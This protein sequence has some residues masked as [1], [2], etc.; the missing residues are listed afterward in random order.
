VRQL[1]SK[2][3]SQGISNE[4]DLAQLLATRWNI[5]GVEEWYFSVKRISKDLRVS[6]DIDLLRVY[7]NRHYPEENRAVGFE[8]KV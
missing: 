4:R 1:T 3:L 5:G 6:P 2:D 7:V 8:L